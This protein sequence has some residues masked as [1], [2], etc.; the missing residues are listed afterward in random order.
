MKDVNSAKSRW[1]VSCGTFRDV[2]RDVNEKLQLQM[3][4]EAN[5]E[6][7]APATTQ[8]NIL[9]AQRQRLRWQRTLNN[10]AV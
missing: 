9:G 4:S 5:T 10:E 7:A 3:S 8:R 2:E 6:T 1:T